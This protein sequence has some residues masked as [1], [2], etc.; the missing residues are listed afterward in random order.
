VRAQEK[1][2]IAYDVPNVQFSHHGPNGETCSFD[3]F[4]AEFHLNDPHLQQLAVIVRGADTGHPELTPQSPG[5][6]A[7]SLGL[8]ALYADDHDM[9][10]QGMLIYDALY[11]WLKNVR[12]ETHNADLF[13]LAS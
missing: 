13:K 2:A 3:A 8:S 6:M 12:N 1:S 5:L 7:V 9:L 11:A 10:E 4:I